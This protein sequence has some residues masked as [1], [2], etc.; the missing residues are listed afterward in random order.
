[1]KGRKQSGLCEAIPVA[2]IAADAWTVAVGV[3]QCSSCINAMCVRGD[4]Y[5][6]IDTLCMRLLAIIYTTER[7]NKSPKAWT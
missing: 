4:S 3:C 7:P 2:Q 6:I 5:L 1:M